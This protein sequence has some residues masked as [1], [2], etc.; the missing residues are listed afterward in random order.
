MFS[1]S[2]SSAAGFA[3]TNELR[4]WPTFGWIALALVVEAALV[5]YIAIRGAVPS[6]VG[7]GVAL[8]ALRA[9]VPT[10][11]VLGVL[12]G[13]LE[14]ALSGATGAAWTVATALTAV[15]IA[16]SN[17]L[18]FVESAVR[19]GVAIA[20]AVLVRDALFWLGMK[21]AGYPSGLGTAH[22]HIALI[23]AVESGIL[24]TMGLAWRRSR[25]A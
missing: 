22:L 21:V 15:I 17:R 14:D 5:P 3:R 1:S 13:A 9:R 2:R 20:I 7:I 12:A 23:S 11:L 25:A 19:L 18:I 4:L 10:A 24:T 16:L 8:F 6:A